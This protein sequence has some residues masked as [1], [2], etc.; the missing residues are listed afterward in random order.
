MDKVVNDRQTEATHPKLT[1]LQ[2][3]FQNGY[4]PI[5]SD[6]KCVSV[7]SSFSCLRFNNFSYFEMPGRKIRGLLSRGLVGTGVLP[8]G[9]LPRWHRMCPHTIAM[10][11]SFGLTDRSKHFYCTNGNS[12]DKCFRIWMYST[13]RGFKTTSDTR[14]PR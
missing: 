7:V 12:S 3:R 1:E 6:E 5:T 14:S 8:L 11:K 2:R 9:Y 10:R 4:F 13:C